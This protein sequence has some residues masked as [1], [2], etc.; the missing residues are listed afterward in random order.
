MSEIKTFIQKRLLSRINKHGVLVVYDPDRRYRELCL[1]M[2]TDEL[3]V[4]DASESSIESREAALQTFLE[5]GHLQTQLK[6]M[7]VY[8]PARPPKT[9]EE[10]LRDPFSLYIVSGSVFPDSDG[11]EYLE[12][13][14]KA[15]PDYATEIRRI[16][17]ENPNPS[18]EVI[19]AVGGGVDWPNLRTILNV[20]SS[21]EIL[22]ALMV[23]SE[24]Q[25]QEL[26][27]QTTW[28]TEAKEL[29]R[30][31]LGLNLLTRNE[32]WEAIADELWRFVLFSE[33]VFDLPETESLPD[34]LANV[35]RA[36]EEAKPLIEEL[37]EVL[38]SDLRK[39]AVYIERAEAIERELRLPDIC[40]TIID[41]GERPT[42]PFEDRTFLEQAIQALE[43]ED[44]DNARKIL[45]RQEQSVW[46]EK[47]ENQSRW[48]VISAALHL[49]EECELY[50]GLL[51][52]HTRSLESLIDFYTGN[53]REVDRLHREFEQ[54]VSDY[55]DGYEPILKMIDRVRNRYWKLIGK[56][57]E[58]FIKNFESGWPPIGRLAN[59]DVFDRFIAPKLQESGRRIV[60]F[61]ID[62]L[63]YELGVALVK[64]LAEEGQVELRAACAQ[65]P[66]VTQVG[67]ASLL[68]EAGR[69]LSLKKN[70][71]GELI[72]FLGEVPVSNVN[73]RMDVLKKRYGQR[74]AEMTL[75]EFLKKNPPLESTVE[76]LVLRSDQIDSQLE[77]ELESALG[78]IHDSL[79]R[80]RVAVNRLKQMGFHEVVIATDHGFV[81]CPSPQAG[82]VCTKP[83]GEWIN[84]HERC[85]LGR[86]TANLDN[87][88]IPAERAGIR[89]DF[90]H[91]ASPKGLVPYR[92]GMQYFHG[93][94]S[95]QE[96]VIPVLVL[97][98]QEKQPDFRNPQVS[99]SY[100]NGAKKITTR[101]PVIEITLEDNSLFSNGMDF[102]I[103]LEAH[104]KRGN[105]VGEAKAGGPVNP[106]T[107][108]IH[109][110]PGDRI[111]VTM[112]MNPDFEGK[113]TIKAMNPTTLTTY[114]KLDLETDYV[115]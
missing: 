51:P 95:L 114:C 53:L 68:P 76:L 89:G 79:K 98:L 52:N 63:R 109:L 11:D 36:K 82:N 73:Q 8:V 38:R 107:K 113:F 2:E 26:E 43:R 15:K 80:I 58:Y 35:P 41:L 40:S 77:N 10:K 111:K 71:K 57:Q 49:I 97:K 81:L 60:F 12:L 28:V 94:V 45:E 4:I 22:L 112:K 5:L 99:L 78:Y 25:K 91:L 20:E 67:M 72:P 104:D 100:K 65:L 9:D 50:E 19:D 27:K 86:G 47:G 48:S 115:V 105:V 44:T 103:L 74:F 34:A 59:A 84:V 87:I 62:A 83:P 85:L 102:E 110:K 31:T 14:I 29:F 108:T 61:M 106:V 69:M 23:P 24:R 101:L 70:D 93:G 66:S 88:V 3:R 64:E 54:A 55:L 33:F 17:S 90:E 46:N 6:G 18:F 32:S 42:F 75:K 96:T 21:R 92:S 30:V 13:C 56:V 1:E 7:L 16:F 39:R 37:C